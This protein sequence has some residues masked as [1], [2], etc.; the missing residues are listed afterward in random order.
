M[1]ATLWYQDEAAEQ[2][3]RKDTLQSTAVA[4][5]IDTE[6]ISIAAAVGQTQ[7][8]LQVQLAHKIYFL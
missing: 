1:E 8:S 4:E 3:D 5:Q 2:L 7:V 6:Q